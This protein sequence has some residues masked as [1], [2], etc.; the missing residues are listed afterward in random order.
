MSNVNESNFV[1]RW[2]PQLKSKWLKLLLGLSLM[3]NL[4]IGGV[5]LGGLFGNHRM[6]R[7]AGVSY[8]Q[9][10]PR[11]FF[12]DLPRDRRQQ[13]MQI[14]KDN[15]DELRQLRATSEASSLK[16]AD[17]LEKP[18]FAIEDIRQTVAAF[19]T[20]TESLA[21]RGGDVVVKIVELLTPEERKLLAQAIRQRDQR[22]SDRK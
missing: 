9:L 5:L 6:E 10:I 11:D 1:G 13:L 19:A 15:K 16:L 8:V 22:D 3:L 18:A 17:A 14:V 21:A 4:G 7:L 20:G 12:R 2:W